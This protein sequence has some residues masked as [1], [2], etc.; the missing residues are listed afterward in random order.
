MDTTAATSPAPAGSLLSER[1]ELKNGTNS[2]RALWLP[3]GTSAAWYILTIIGIYSVIIL[4]RLASNILGKHDKV[5]EDA[6]HSNLTSELTRKERGSRV[7]ECSSLTIS[8]TIW[9][10]TA[11]LQPSPAGPSTATQGT[12][13]KIVPSPEQFTEKMGQCGPSCRPERAHEV[14]QVNGA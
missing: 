3:D 11:A 6:Y 10:A 2:T 13:G 5:S 9:A 4:F 14:L 7:S 1:M 12:P 8:N